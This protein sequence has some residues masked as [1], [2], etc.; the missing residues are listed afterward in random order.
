VSRVEYLDVEDALTLVRRLGIGPVRDL[1]L[2]DSALARS[3]STAFG[4]DAYP[5]IALKAVALLHSVVRNHAL[6]DGNKRLGWLATVVFLDLNR[7]AVDLVDGAA[8]DLVIDVAT[9]TADL[10][11]IAGR[12]R[13]VPSRSS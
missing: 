5:T 3:R 12:L 7:C 6:V 13:I 1:G 8:F 4:Q 2:L 9:G 10:E 11:K